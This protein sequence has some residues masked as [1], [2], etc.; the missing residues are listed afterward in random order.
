MGNDSWKEQAVGGGV[1]ARKGMNRRELMKG[2]ALVAAAA[3]MPVAAARAVERREEPAGGAKYVAKPNIVIASTYK[4]VVETDSGK[5]FGYEQGGLKIFRGIPYGAST[6]G[7]RRFMA[8]VKPEPWVGER[9]ALYW[10]HVAPQP[11]TAT[12][13]G[14]RGLSTARSC[15]MFST[16]RMSARR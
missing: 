14:R 8:P 15:L 5:V 7:K 12:L 2:S 6:G 1:Q 11:F 13:D 3:A 16:W 9:S 10:G 4:N